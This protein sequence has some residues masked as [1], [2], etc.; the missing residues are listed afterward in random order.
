MKLIYLLFLFLVANVFANAQTT[1]DSPSKKLQ[2]SASMGT[3]VSYFKMYNIPDSPPYESVE[4]RLGFMLTKP[5]NKVLSLRAGLFFGTKFKR[6]SYYFGP[7]KQFTTHA[8]VIK[9]LDETVSKRNHYMFDIPVLL[10]INL[11]GGAVGLKVGAN[12]RFWTPNNSDV[13]PLT[14]LHEIGVFTGVNRKLSKK[15]TAG[16]DFYA[17]YTN[18]FPAT[19]IYGPRPI[20]V[21]NQYIQFF[22]EY[23]L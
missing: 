16:I 4:S 5:L 6:E 21:T 9:P 18:I 17:G 12:P 10:Q 2:L 7:N 1:E 14:A 23:S 19:I 3:G 13:D 20:K 22:L 11:F 15:L 8:T